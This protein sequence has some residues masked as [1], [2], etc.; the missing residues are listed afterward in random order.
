MRREDLAGRRRHENA[1]DADTQMNHGHADAPD[2]LAGDE[3]ARAVDRVDDE[4]R[5]TA[6]PVGILAALLG[7][8]AIVGA[9]RAEALPEQGVDG[10]VGFADGRAAVVLVPDLRIAPEIVQRQ[11]ARL[12]RGLADEGEIGRRHPAARARAQRPASV[13][14]SMASVGAAVANLRSMSL[15]GVTRM[16]MSFRLEA[17]VTS[18]TG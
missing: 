11:L 13:M 9:R 17:M 15:A 12:L 16:N 2:V 14:P 1:G 4:E 5:V 10:N 6:D 7:K 3:A 8:P 18:E